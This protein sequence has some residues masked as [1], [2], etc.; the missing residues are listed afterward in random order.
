VALLYEVFR[1]RVK[2]IPKT[3]FVVFPSIIGG[4]IDGIGFENQLK[5]LFLSLQCSLDIRCLRGPPV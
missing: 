2:N 4:F 5:M 1:I 3:V